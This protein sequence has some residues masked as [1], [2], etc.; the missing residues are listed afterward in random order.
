M[1]RGRF[2]G[3]FEFVEN[4]RSILA[5]VSLFGPPTVTD[6]DRWGYGQRMITNPMTKDKFGLAVYF[7]DGTVQGVD[8]YYGAGGT[9]GTQ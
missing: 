5:P 4:V 7:S 6:S 2:G 3:D 9:G 1:R 8:Y